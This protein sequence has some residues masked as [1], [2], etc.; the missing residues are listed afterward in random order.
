MTLMTMSSNVFVCE[1]VLEIP[2]L[3]DLNHLHRLVA[4]GID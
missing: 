1:I 4:A 3:V 2:F